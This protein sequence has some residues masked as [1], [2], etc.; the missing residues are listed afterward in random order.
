MNKYGPLLFATFAFFLVPVVPGWK[1]AADLGLVDIK[2]IWIRHCDD[3]E[4]GG[5][6]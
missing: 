3:K 4:F 2:S 6:F 5:F 1:T